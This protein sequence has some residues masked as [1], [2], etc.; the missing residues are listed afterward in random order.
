MWPGIWV[1]SRT[2]SV[3]WDLRKVSWVLASEEDGWLSELAEALLG[4]ARGGK[5]DEKVVIERLCLSLSRVEKPFNSKVI[6]SFVPELR[7]RKVFRI[8]GFLCY[9]H[10]SHIQVWLCNSTNQTCRTLLEKQW[11][12]RKWCTPVDPRIWPIKSRTTSSNIHTAA[13]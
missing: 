4:A 8:S 10:I 11:W 5:A 7:S 3:G 13:M 9:L 2:G 6:K 12:A 1:T